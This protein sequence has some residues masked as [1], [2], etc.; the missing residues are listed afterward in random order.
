[1]KVGPH[2]A[3]TVINSFILELIGK[4][5]PASTLKLSHLLKQHQNQLL[6]KQLQS[7]EL[8]TLLPRRVPVGNVKGVQERGL[9]EMRDTWQMIHF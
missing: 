6:Q 8:S 5:M 2:P 4:N 3:Q 7:H 1:M 9:T